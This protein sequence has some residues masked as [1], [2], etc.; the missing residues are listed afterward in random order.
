MIKWIF[1]PEKKK[2]VKLTAREMVAESVKNDPLTI[3]DEKVALAK[4]WEVEPY[5]YD[6]NKPSA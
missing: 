5:R 3:Q 1:H 6:G 4:G 2:I